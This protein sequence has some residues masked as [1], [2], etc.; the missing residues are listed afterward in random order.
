MK[1][2]EQQ[3]EITLWQFV[4]V[5]VFIT[6]GLLFMLYLQGCK[7]VKQCPAYADTLS[8]V[9]IPGLVF[10]EPEPHEMSKQGFIPYVFSDS[11]TTHYAMRKTALNS[12]ASVSPGKYYI[13]IRST[14]LTL[15]AMRDTTGRWCYNDPLKSI[16]VL[17]DELY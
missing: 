15:L 16:E 6:L 8:T 7:T 17:I 13:F 9:K 3:S 2:N 12:R 10:L 1:N 14:D 5:L 11:S 4:K